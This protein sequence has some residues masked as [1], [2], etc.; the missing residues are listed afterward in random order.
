MEVTEIEIAKTKSSRI[1]PRRAIDEDGLRELADSIASVGVMQPITVRP[2]SGGYEVVLGERRLR[3]AKM[4]GLKKIPAII[5]NIPDDE[6]LELMLIENAQREDLNDIEKGNSCLQLLKTYPDRYPDRTVLADK[7][8]VSEWSVNNWIAVAKE[9]P[10]EIQNLVGTQEKRGAP[11]PA[12][13]ITS[14]IA[15]R[16]SKSVHE[17]DRKVEVA[18]EFAR[19]SIPVH[20]AREVLREVAKQKETPVE[21]VITKVLQ[22]PPEL[23]F[24]LDHARSIVAGVKTQTSRFF[25]PDELENMV[26]G[27]V[28]TANIWE[29]RFAQL[30]AIRV[31]KKRLGEFKEEDAQREGGYSLSEFRKAWESIHGAGSWNPKT[32]VIVVQF[33]L[34]N[35]S[36]ELDLK[37]K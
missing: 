5:R 25:R 37:D 35:H 7:L 31:D 19:R 33:K 1:N 29:P 2:A 8:G 30:K 22:A 27:A 20:K 14:Q 12:G 24:R 9:V 26:P 16:I 23:P 11:V 4:A 34:L 13:T 28:V 36:T 6:A 32:E 3:A 10:P 21:A 18:R 15:L 17:P